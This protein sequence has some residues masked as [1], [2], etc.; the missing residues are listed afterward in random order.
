MA[1][2]KDLPI[3]REDIPLAQIGEPFPILSILGRV[4]Q[5]GGNDDGDFKVGD[6]VEVFRPFWADYIVT[7][8]TNARLRK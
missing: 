1:L 5:I 8:K 6:I 3:K 4:L 7:P 2:R